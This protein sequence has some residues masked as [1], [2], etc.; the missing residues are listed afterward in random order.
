MAPTEKEKRRMR[1]EKKAQ[2]KRLFETK[3]RR[4][5]DRELLQVRMAYENYVKA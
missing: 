5:S 1:R 4:W 2:K 3:V